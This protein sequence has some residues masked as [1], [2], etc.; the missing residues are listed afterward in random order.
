M[1]IKKNI[2][3]VLEGGGFRGCYTAGALKWLLDNGIHMPYSVSI[4]A[5]TAYAFFY[6]VGN[7]K[8]MKDVSTKG[9]KDK[10]VLGVSAFFREGGF[11]GYNYLRDHYLLPY[12]D[13]A[14]KQLK[15]S[16]NEVE[17]GIFNMDKE[18]LEYFGKNDFDDKASHIKA[19]CVLPITGK[20]TTINGEK[21]LDGG[22]KHMVSIERS[23]ATGHDKNLV[24]V[25][26]DKNYVRK[27]NSPI[28]S[29]LLRVLYGKYKKTLATIDTRVETYYEEMN[30]V[31]RREEEGKAI[32]IRPSRDCGV[33][34]FSGT[35]EQMEDMFQLGWQDMEDRKEDI[36]KFLEVK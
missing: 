10:N 13:D 19:S 12:Y 29:F 5:A 25:T 24:I 31:Y 33:G 1:E 34:R 23:E 17:V 14:L 21:F 2:G 18:Q 35:M 4:S 6:S 9:V 32:L 7:V 16:N 26:K 28:V 11:V 27:P 3:L 30:W 22:I 36:F 8:A 15:T 20:M